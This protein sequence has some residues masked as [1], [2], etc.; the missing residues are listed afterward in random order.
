M[1]IFEEIKARGFQDVVY[2]IGTDHARLP[3][4]MVQEGVC[5][6]AVAT[7]IGDGPLGRAERNVR[8]YGLSG[9]V[10]L[11]RGD[12]FQAISR[13]QAGRIAVISGMGGLALAKI[14]AEG[15]ERAKSASMLVLQP[16]NNQDALRRWLDENGFT[17]QFERLARED[18]RVYVALF[19]KWTGKIVAYGPERYF[20]G[21]VF[22]RCAAA[23]RL[24]YLGM[25][26]RKIENRLR[27]LAASGGARA[28]AREAAELGAALRYLDAATER[29]RAEALEEME[30]E[31]DE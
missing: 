26:Q 31:G 2:D 24:A 19:C 21:T 16:M 22:V 1:M 20:A 23:L 6:A 29:A 4:R 9:R 14:A 11:E 5:G 7:D 18:R 12:G 17:I 13:Y 15:D 25:V 27:G 30:R 28:G 8:A 3:I 10:V